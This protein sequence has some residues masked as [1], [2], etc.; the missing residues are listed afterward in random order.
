MV[1]AINNSLD[2][3]SE[4]IRLQYQIQSIGYNPDLQKV[5]NNI[6]KM[7]DELSKIEVVA[8]RTH[9]NHYAKNKVEEINQAIDRL[10]KLLLIA[11]LMQ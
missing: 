2:W 8:R 3:N 10:E 9:V 6:G 11:R 1:M 5:F 7:V 4:G